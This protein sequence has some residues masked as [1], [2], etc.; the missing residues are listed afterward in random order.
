MKRRGKC[1]DSADISKKKCCMTTLRE[2]TSSNIDVKNLNLEDCIGASKNVS[3]ELTN[4][5]L[6]DLT[7]Q[8]TTSVSVISSTPMLKKE[9]SAFD[10]NEQI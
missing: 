3:I 8:N 2:N 7:V 1:Q 10:M 9:T 6:I 5:E 4:F